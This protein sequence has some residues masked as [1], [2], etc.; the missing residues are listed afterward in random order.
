MPA[1]YSP[2]QVLSFVTSA[3]ARHV[4]EYRS[5]GLR[6]GCHA[7][8]RDSQH[9]LQASVR[10]QIAFHRDILNSSA[11][12]Q[13]C[14]LKVCEEHLQGCIAWLLVAASFNPATPIPMS[15]AEDVTYLKQDLCCGC[16][17]GVRVLC[18]FVVLVVVL[19]TFF[20]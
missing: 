20:V 1:K 8:C 12:P 6:G 10:V 7:A 5:L 15:W 2:H 16:A 14:D 19:F 18:V 13:T 4:A 11:T 9:I 17:F 3:A